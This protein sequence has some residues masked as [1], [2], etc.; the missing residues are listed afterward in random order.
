MVAKSVPI[1]SRLMTECCLICKEPLYIQ[2]DRCKSYNDQFDKYHSNIININNNKNGNSDDDDDK[3]IYDTYVGSAYESE[4][5]DYVDDNDAQNNDIENVNGKKI[6]KVI[7]CTKNHG[8]HYHCVLI[9]SNLE[10][11]TNSTDT[12]A[13]TIHT[14]ENGK[15]KVKKKQVM[16]ACPLCYQQ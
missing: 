2:C 5:D 15:R 8:C 4:Q 6:C 3:I 12:H 13:S 9:K 11:G 7:F 16:N 14:D 10:F 1:D